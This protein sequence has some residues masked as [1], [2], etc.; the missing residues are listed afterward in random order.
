MID[1]DTGS[2]E[3]AAEHLSGDGHAQDVAGELAMSML[4][5]DVSSAFEDLHTLGLSLLPARRRV[6]RKFRGL[7]PCVAG[8]LPDVR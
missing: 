2:V 6:C 5:V 4:V 7:D 8:R 1:G 3:L